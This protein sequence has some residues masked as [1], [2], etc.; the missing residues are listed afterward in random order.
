MFV[1]D[2]GTLRMEARI[3]KGH[4]VSMDNGRH[5]VLGCSG[6]DAATY[7]LAGEWAGG[8]AG[9]ACNVAVTGRLV[10]YSAGP[11]RGGSVRVRVTF[12]GD[13]DGEPTTHVGGWMSAN[14][15]LYRKPDLNPMD[16][17][18]CGQGCT[19]W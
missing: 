7:R 9:W 16:W 14:E 12:P 5:A 8:L 11:F 19:G 13:G 3:F 1:S 6:W 10:R 15:I 4:T 17:C 18:R 2:G